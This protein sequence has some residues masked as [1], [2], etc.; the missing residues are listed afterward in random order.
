MHLTEYKADKILKLNIAS[1]FQGIVLYKILQQKLVQKVNIRD[2]SSAF[3]STIGL[4]HPSFM[5]YY[6]IDGV[7]KSLPS[8]SRIIIFLFANFYAYLALRL[9]NFVHAQ[10]S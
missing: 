1:P 5:R 7:R 8:A 9:Y 3:T 4:G 2:Q 6:L 10:L